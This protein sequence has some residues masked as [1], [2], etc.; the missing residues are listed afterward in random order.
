MAGYDPNSCFQLQPQ[1][2]DRSIDQNRNKNGCLS[3]EIAIAT[4]TTREKAIIVR[5][6]DRQ[7]VSIHERQCRLEIASGTA[8]CCLES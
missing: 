7:I 5:R 2:V 4:C 1:K 6:I 8:N 3:G